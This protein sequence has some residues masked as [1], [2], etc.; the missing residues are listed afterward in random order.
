MFKGAA[1]VFAMVIMAYPVYRVVSLH[2]DRALSANETILYL[3]ALLFLFLGII[4]GWG[5]P[6][7]WMLLLALLVGCLGLPLINRLADHVA[8]RRM[9]D[10]DIRKFAETL[11]SQPRNTFLHGR[12]ARIFLSRREY[13]LAMSH[14]KQARDISPQ[15][16]A[17]KRLV[18]RIETEQRREELHL[19]VCPKCFT[20]NPATAGACGHCGFHFIDPSDLL[21][22]LA[23]P[24]A[25]EVAKWS[26][27]ALLFVGLML[28][29]IRASLLAAS[30]LM[31]VGIASLFWC[32]YGLF[33]RR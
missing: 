5:T 19:K 33:S 9:E 8:L 30:L 18:E 25:L 29:I 26:G 20:E 21:R 2:F 7:G 11:R 1:I 13:E 24:P 17:F 6:L 12:L 4:I 27:L 3:T 32:L 14:A 16:P 22:L 28:L 31:M 15:D 10:D 23:T